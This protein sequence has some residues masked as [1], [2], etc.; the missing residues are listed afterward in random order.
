MFHS[1]IELISLFLAGILAGEELIVR[2]GVQPALNTLDDRSHLLSRIALVRKLMIVVPAIMIP[3]VIAGLV[4]V[5]TGGTGTGFV[6]RIL[7]AMMLVAFVLFSFLGTVP[8]NMK[9]NDTWN[10]DTPPA[11]WKK[12]V[13]RWVF[14][15]TFRSSSAILAF[16]FFLGAVV[17]Q[18]K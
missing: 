7:G 17:I 14:I 10:A 4:V 3:T 2:Y 6:F 15:D 12:T 18:L 1:I 9:V 5:A 13:K 8:I 16:V 11:D